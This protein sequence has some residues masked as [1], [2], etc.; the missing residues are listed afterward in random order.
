M[1]TNWKE[2][3]K[4]DVANLDECGRKITFTLP[5][6]SVGALLSAATRAVSRQVQVPGFRPGKA[7]ASL[8]LARY[9]NYILDEAERQVEML[10]F[11]RLSDKTDEMDLISCGRIQP[12][13]K[14]EAGKDY[15]MTA[16]AEVAPEIQLPDY[17]A[18]PV[19]VAIDETAEARAE[20]LLE[21][22]KS[23]YSEF[24]DLK[25]PAKAG[26]MLRVSYESDLEVP[27]GATEAVKHAA[28]SENSWLYLVQPEQI[29]GATEALLGAEVDK[30]YSFTAEY[31][32]DWREEALRGKKAQYKVKVLG[33]QRRQAVEDLDKL[34]E[35]LG[36]KSVDEMKE[37]FAKRAE[38]DLEQMR[39]QKAMD[40]IMQALQK[41]TPA[42]VLPKKAFDAAVQRELQNI[43]NETVRSEEDAEKFKAEKDAHMDAAK[44]N[45]EEALR[46][47]FIVR[48]I[49]KLEKISLT[50]QEISDHL[51]QMSAYTGIE[52]EKLVQLLQKSGRINE[53]ETELLIGKTLDALAERNA[54]KQ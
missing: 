7:P 9:K 34:A 15:V 31:P 17:N 33:G 1:T 36:A 25:E 30:E 38:A 45:A 39:R 50:E 41:D 20:K 27:E 47:Q 32:Q 23:Y 10:A 22:A 40:Q 29:P 5:G 28:K 21:Q 53:L 16:E 4:L 48:K 26:D 3:F 12:E 51:R 44:K 18:I 13:G 54:K 6:D 14:P 35:K 8:V 46:K 52:P 2:Q 11:E 49:A 37:T 43:A 42:F 24:V 19:D